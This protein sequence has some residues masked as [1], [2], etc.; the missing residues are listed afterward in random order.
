M[1]ILKSL[2]KRNTK[3]FF[4]D[5]GLLFTSLITP[6]ILL[7][8]YAT[9]LGNLYEDSFR[10]ILESIGGADIYR[11]QRQSGDGA[12]NRFANSCAWLYG[13]LPKKDGSTEETLRKRILESRVEQV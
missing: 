3:M 8:L 11:H 4:K 9:F 2:I 12:T 1:S 10:Q 5:K 6:M 13:R 7:V